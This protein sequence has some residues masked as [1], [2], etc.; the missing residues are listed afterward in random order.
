MGCQ[1]QCGGFVSIIRGL[2][3]Q[4]VVSE[5]RVGR[6]GNYGQ[7]LIRY[8]REQRRRDECHIQV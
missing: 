3:C 7:W 4:L 1:G 2:G 8:S 5:R 6:T